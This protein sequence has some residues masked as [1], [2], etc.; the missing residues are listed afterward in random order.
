[1]EKEIDPTNL[2]KQAANEMDFFQKHMQDLIDAKQATSNA[3]VSKISE[4]VEAQYRKDWLPTT[5]RLLSEKKSNLTT[6]NE[7]LGLPE[8]MF[9]DDNIEDVIIDTSSVIDCALASH[10]G[11]VNRDILVPLESNVM[12]LLKQTHLQDICNIWIFQNIDAN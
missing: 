10:I 3:L 9:E 5:M 7:N 11:A 1:M 6:A 8:K 2:I 12:A 4:V